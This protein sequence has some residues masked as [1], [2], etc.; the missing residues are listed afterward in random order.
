MKAPT[1][2]GTTR[3]MAVC[4]GATCGARVEFGEKRGHVADRRG[5]R[6]WKGCGGTNYSQGCTGDCNDNGCVVME[7]VRDAN[8]REWM[9]GSIGGGN[10]NQCFW[11]LGSRR[12][13]VLVAN[14]GND[15]GRR[16]EM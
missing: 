16:R 3:I 6:G 5:C 1:L 2:L 15:S 9:V 14:V 12:L 13:S 8:N 10:G 11:H 7:G 4:G